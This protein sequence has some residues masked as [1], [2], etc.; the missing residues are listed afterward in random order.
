MSVSQ[1]ALA[2][3][4]ALSV[5]LLTASASADA[6]KEE[7]LF[8]QPHTGAFIRLEEKDKRAVG[9]FAHLARNGF[10]FDVKLS[11]PLDAET[12]EASLATTSS[13]APGFSG[14]LALGFDSRS[15][16]LTLKGIERS[17]ANL[18]RACEV[19]GLYARSAAGE[20]PVCSGDAVDAWYADYLEHDRHTRDLKCSAQK[21]GVLERANARADAKN[22]PAEKALADARGA[23]DAAAKAL[24]NPPPA[25]SASDVEELSR[26]A[27]AA[28][29][30]L[31]EQSAKTAEARDAANAIRK[32]GD[33][34]SKRREQDCLAATAYLDKQTSCGRGQEQCS[35]ARDLL[36][37]LDAEAAGVR[38]DIDRNAVPRRGGTYHSAVIEGTY[39]FDRITVYDRTNIAANATKQNDY[40]VEV[41]PRYDLYL[42]PAWAFSVRAGLTYNR[43]VSTTTAKRCT[44]A[45]SADAA[46][47]GESCEDVRVLKR[48]PSAEFAGYGRVSAMYLLRDAIPKAVPG[49]EAR[50]AIEQLGQT[51]EVQFRINAFLSPVTGPVLSRF[52]IGVDWYLPLQTN[53]DKDMVAGKLRQVRP[54]LLI[55]ASL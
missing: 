51:S 27:R 23:S 42:A 2:S 19:L 16:A 36:A 49:L 52:G 50:V 18:D 37:E 5:T 6:S 9:R 54:F 7:S 55:G 14:R 45:P 39:A 24:A 4:V 40:D 12:R 32:T 53:S 26:L 1:R 44:T 28:T 41:G 11:A 31:D 10:L 48:D 25:A 15:A 22:V 33:S 20:D 47:K 21:A 35:A 38:R 13:A 29:L 17:I 3:T 43:D 34:E 30:A 8:A 46:V